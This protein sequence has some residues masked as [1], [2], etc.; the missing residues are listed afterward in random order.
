MPSLKV[1]VYLLVSILGGGLILYL[2]ARV[3]G[4]G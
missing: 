2:T 1:I 3:I 4:F